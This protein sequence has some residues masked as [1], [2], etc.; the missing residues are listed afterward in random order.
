MIDVEDVARDIL[1][2]DPT[3]VG[4]VPATRI[5]LAPMPTDTAFPAISVQEISETTDYTHEGPALVKHRVQIDAWAKTKPAAKAVAVAVRNAIHAYAGSE[6]NALDFQSAGR[7][8]L[9]ELDTKLYRISSDFFAWS[10][11][12]AA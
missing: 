3:V 12:Q 1:A 5:H 10:Q 11:D 8:S 2:A 7:R 6:A 4:L 9:Y